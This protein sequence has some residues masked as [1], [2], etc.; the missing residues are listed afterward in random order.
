MQA[1][2]DQ[3]ASAL[4]KLQVFVV[5]GIQFIAL[6]IEHAENVPVI[7]AHRHNDLGTSR[8]KRRQIPKILAYVA[9]DE[10]LAGLQ[11]RTAQSLSNRETWIRRRFIAALG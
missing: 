6:G 3:T 9:H 5:E 4:K 2:R 11:G 10:R 7:V 8:M 1:M